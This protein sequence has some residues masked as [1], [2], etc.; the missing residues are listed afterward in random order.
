VSAVKY[1]HAVNSG[2]N[3]AGVSVGNAG[4]SF[5]GQFITVTNI[6]GLAL[7]QTYSVVLEALP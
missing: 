3:N 2:A 6:P 7:G 5:D 4:W 1:A